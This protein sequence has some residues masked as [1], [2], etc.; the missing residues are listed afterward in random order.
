LDPSFKCSSRFR[1]C[2]PHTVSIANSRM[3]PQLDLQHPSPAV[4]LLKSHQQKSSCLY[5]LFQIIRHVE[6]LLWFSRICIIVYT[7]GVHSS[8]TVD[9]GSYSSTSANSHLA[10]FPTKSPPTAPEGS[11]WWG[12]LTRPEPLSLFWFLRMPF[13]RLSAG[14]KGER[15]DGW[16][17]RGCSLV[18]VETAIV[19]AM[20][21]GGGA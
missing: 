13:P 17:G 15:H 14:V 7:E 12:S 3:Q 19:D 16:G 9:N 20:A 6:G 4:F 8:C 18:D 5:L 10:G 2:S 11:Q 1:S 21:A